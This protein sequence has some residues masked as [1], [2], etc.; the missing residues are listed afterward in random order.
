MWFQR[1]RSWR[2]SRADGEAVEASS[3]CIPIELPGGG[4]VS[5]LR[6]VGRWQE[7]VRKAR[8]P[9][10]ER[11]ILV[12][13]LVGE[14]HHRWYGEAWLMGRFRF[15]FLLAQGLSPRER[16][17]DLGCGAGRLGIWLIPYLE[18]G[19]YF[20]V[21]PHLRSLVAFS[22]YEAVLHGLTDR[23]PRLLLDDQFRLG[24]FGE[25][26]D[27][28]VDVSVTR[29]LSG[30]AFRRAYVEVRS[31]LAP[32]GRIV[33]GGLAPERLEQLRR[34]G[35]TLLHVG[36]PERPLPFVRR[37]PSANNTVHVLRLGGTSPS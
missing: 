33:V 5:A 25:R 16:V 19:R 24:H 27:V 26:F 32:G 13:E 1:L 12:E 2:R 17:L 14:K 31:V 10:E 9:P 8:R 30:E 37:R 6:S 22:A 7:L 34:E 36:G 28:V 23:R 3:L 21:D 35:F 29:F 15:D 18:P 11:P 20:G 4:T